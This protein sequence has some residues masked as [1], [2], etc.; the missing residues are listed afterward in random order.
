MDT[1]RVCCL[2]TSIFYYYAST[3]RED[4]CLGNRT[5]AIRNRGTHDHAKP[6]IV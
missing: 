5:I 1:A 6:S 4:V 3:F 2:A